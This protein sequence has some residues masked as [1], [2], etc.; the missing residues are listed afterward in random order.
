MSKR[1]FLC[2]F[3]LLL[4]NMTLYFCTVA[5]G[6]SMDTRASSSS[7]FVAKMQEKSSGRKMEWILT[8]G[9]R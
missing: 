4:I 5:L 6:F 3:L 9:K 7:F 8:Q 2:T 1:A